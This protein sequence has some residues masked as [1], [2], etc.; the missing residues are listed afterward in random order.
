MSVI[1]EKLVL[2]KNPAKNVFTEFN[3]HGFSELHKYVTDIKLRSEN[4][5]R[6]IK[7][8]NTAD[9]GKILD[10]TH[11]KTNIDIPNKLELYIDKLYIDIKNEDFVDEDPGLY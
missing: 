2:E 1:I 6:Y 10:L 9:I 3:K 11:D 5:K 8:S 4:P 7:L